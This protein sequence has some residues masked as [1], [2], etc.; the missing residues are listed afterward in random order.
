MTEQ[1]P[2]PPPSVW[3]PPAGQPVDDL[4]KSAYASWIRRVG[5]YLIDYVLLLIVGAIAGVVAGVVD[6]ACTTGSCGSWSVLARIIHAVLYLAPLTF[7]IWNEGSRQG[8]TGSS[9]GKSVLKFKVLNERTGEPI[10]FGSSVAR[11]FAHFVDAIIFG[12]GYLLPLVT[13]KRQT[14]ADMMMGT[15]CLPNEPPSVQRSRTPWIIAGAVAVVVAI[16]AVLVFVFGGHKSKSREFVLPFT[17][18]HNPRGVAVDNTG[19]VYVADTDN[20]RVLK[21]PTGAT[22][23]TTLPFTGLNNPVGVA[24]DTTGATYV[25]D[26]GNSR[27]LKLPAGAATP[28]TLPFTGVTD[29]EGVAFDGAGAVYVVAS[30]KEEG[31]TRGQV[32]KLAPGDTN[33]TTLPFTFFVTALGGPSGVAVDT[34]GTVYVADGRVL[35]LTEGA[36]AQDKLPLS[37]PTNAGGAWGVAVDTA[38]KVYITDPYNQRVVKLATGSAPE[39]VVFTGRG[40][41]YGVAVDSAGNVYV[42][43]STTVLKL[44]AG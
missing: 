5:A 43:D 10:G 15:V 42:T 25:A 4:P 2:V 26:S 34:A 7:L 44:P 23:P 29:P 21:L 9:I 6:S 38:G 28:T 20:N 18:L 13:A 27:V 12:I 40:Q 22:T 39:V 3:P 24:V 36:A 32:L 1:P 31:G 17:G 11:Y 35:R 14:I 16:V 37:D 33:P 41:P 19:A 8:I 30:V